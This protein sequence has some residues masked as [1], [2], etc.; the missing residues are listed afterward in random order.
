MQAAAERVVV[1]GGL[2]LVK[3]IATEFA[4]ATC[5]VVMQAI[6]VPGAVLGAVPV[7]CT[8][9][10]DDCCC[11]AGTGKGSDCVVPRISC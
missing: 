9:G 3:G 6:T 11:Y 8:C 1:N 4:P 2:Q 10:P 7:V 5:K